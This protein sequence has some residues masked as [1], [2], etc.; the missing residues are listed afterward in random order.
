MIREDLKK[1]LKSFKEEDYYKNVDL[2]IHSDLS[3]GKM[4]VQDIIGYAEKYNMHYI[5]ITDHNSLGAYYSSAENNNKIIEGVEFDCIHKGIFIHILGYGIDINNDEIKLLLA[6][7]K[8]GSKNKIIRLLYLRDA[9]KVIEIIKKSGG[10][11]VLAHPACYWAINLDKYIKSLIDTGLEGLEV[12]YPY[13]RLRGIFKFHKR[14]TVLKI[15]EKY[16]L[17]KTGGSDTHSK[18]YDNFSLTKLSI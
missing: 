13:K 3:D 4:S 14:K 8:S 5:S 6:K 10:V 12:Y 18:N 9:K 7:N 15:A 2:H 17:I 1:L 16:N 11:P